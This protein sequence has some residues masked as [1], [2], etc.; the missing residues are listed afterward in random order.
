MKNFTTCD[1][2]EILVLVH[3]ITRRHI[4]EG[5]HLNSMYFHSPGSVFVRLVNV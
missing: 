4:T 1:A 2:G 5:S 3:Q